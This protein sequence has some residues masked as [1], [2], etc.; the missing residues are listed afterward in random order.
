MTAPKP[1]AP[2]TDASLALGVA[3][4][5]H[6]R[7]RLDLCVPARP[8]G[9]VAVIAASGW[10]DAPRAEA[11]GAMLALAEAGW[12]SA[13]CD[14]R[15]PNQTR[16]PGELVRDLRAGAAKAWDEAL[17]AGA[18]DQGIAL[19]GVGAG[20]WVALAT[21]LE[22][23]ATRDA[24]TP[25]L[26]ALVGIGLPGAGDPAV[27]TGAGV[28]GARFLA[29]LGDPRTADPTRL[30]PTL[31]LHGESDPDAPLRLTRELAERYAAAGAE[32]RLASM[33]GAGRL[34]ERHESLAVLTSFLGEHAAAR[35]AVPVFAGRIPE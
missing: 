20:A 35:P 33:P 10:T 34:G 30:P 5:D 15:G 1:A 12:A 7:H 31:L 6:P 14:L 16:D 24:R 17:A 9:A 25:R 13:L 22:W 28:A 27:L 8:N 32:C 2:V 18:D 19:I 4:G 21:A 23:P 3:Y 26:R 29:P 11:R